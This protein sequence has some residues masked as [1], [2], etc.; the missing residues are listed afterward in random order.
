[1]IAFLVME[2]LLL[3]VFSILDLVLF[4]IFFESVLIPMFLI[5]GIWG[6]RERKVRAAYMLFLYTLI[7]S[8]LMLL[9]ILLIYAIAGTTDYQTLLTVQFDGNLQ[10]VLWLAFFASFA[11]KVPMVPV[12]IWLPE[13][14]V[15]APTA[16]SVILAGVLLKLGS[17]GLLRFSMPLFPIGTVYFTPLVYAMAAIAVVYTSLT[18]IRQSDMKRIIAYASVAHMNVILV[19]MFALN[20]NGLEGAMIQQLSH[21]LVSSA[22]FLGVGVLYDRH[23]SRLVKYYGGMAHVMPIFVMIFLFFTM[24]NI[25]LPGTSSFVGEFLILVGAFQANTMVT[26]LAATGMVL[27]GAYSLWLYNRVAFGNLKVQSIH[28]FSDINRR[29]F[30][31]QL[32]L[33][34]GT[35]LMGI[36]PEIFLDPMHVSIANLVEQI[37]LGIS[38]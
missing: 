9:A 1:M 16:G 14:H 29:E 31:V 11:T 6:S 19:G 30:F 26:M 8:V 3:I 27:G 21:G 10:K 33:I 35:L 37:N 7:G 34:L 17:Y 22:L 15:E 18:A 24:A 5:V 4:Y 23:H 28:E 38:K 32:P 25:A 20:A 2:T 36:Y 12:H 13:A